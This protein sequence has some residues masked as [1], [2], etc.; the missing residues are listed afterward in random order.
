MFDI[1]G[2]YSKIKRRLHHIHHQAFPWLTLAR[3]LVLPALPAINHDTFQIA[4]STF[5]LH[6]Q[7]RR[8]WHL[9][10]DTSTVYGGWVLECT[11]QKGGGAWFLVFF[12]FFLARFLRG[13]KQTH[14]T[15]LRQMKYLTS[16][17]KWK[18]NLLHEH[19]QWKMFRYHKGSSFFLFSQ[20]FFWS[21]LRLPPSRVPRFLDFLRVS[22]RSFSSK[23]QIELHKNRVRELLCSRLIKK[24][25]K[26]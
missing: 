20:V 17:K 21:F 2:K 13:K 24:N 15:R 9:Q 6:S 10:Y 23:K 16:N 8:T 19:Y 14:Q 3:E 5:S 26:R 4:S 25:N 22:S 11:C 7:I 12:F 1:S 18:W